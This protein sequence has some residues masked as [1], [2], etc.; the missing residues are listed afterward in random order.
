MSARGPQSMVRNTSFHA[1][2]SGTS[3]SLRRMV[4]PATTVR[5]HTNRFQHEN[6]ARLFRAR[7]MECSGKN[8]LNELDAGFG[9]LE[10]LTLHIIKQCFGVDVAGVHLAGGGL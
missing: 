10:G 7:P 4:P 2:G 8:L 3:N 9:V 6:G 5:R 1:S